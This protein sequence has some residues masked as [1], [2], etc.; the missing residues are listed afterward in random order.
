MSKKLL[1]VLL[2]GMSVSMFS[3]ADLYRWKDA[4]GKIHYSDKLPP[5]QARQAHDKLN[6]SGVSKKNYSR[7]KTDDERAQEKIAA[8]KAAEKRREEAASLARK[9]AKDQILLDTFSSEEDM[10]HTRDD[11]LE[12]IS[13]DIK[14]SEAKRARIL[15]RLKDR[16]ASADDSM[17][18]YGKVADSKLEE[19]DSIKKQI[20]KNEQYVSSRQAKYYQMEKEFNSDLKRYRELKGI[21]PVVADESVKNETLTERAKNLLT[22]PSK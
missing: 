7:D 12:A 19:I 13:L 4:N 9:R 11:R 22:T 18:R 5:G 3:H 16:Q 1:A 2:I 6:S 15:E 14:F 20:A 17:K 10:I 8:K 21:K